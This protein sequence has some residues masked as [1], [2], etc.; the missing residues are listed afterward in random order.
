M[1]RNENSRLSHN[2]NELNISKL[3]ITGWME[4]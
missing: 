2:I 4:Q 3:K 1:L